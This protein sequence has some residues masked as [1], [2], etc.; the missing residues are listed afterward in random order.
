MAIKQRTGLSSLSS[1][2]QNPNVKSGVF[3]ARVIY[4]MLDDQTQVKAFKEFG[5]WSSIGCIFFDQ[6][7]Q[8]NPNPEF[9][10]DNFAK[11]LFPN[12]SIVPLENEIVYIIAL[13][14]S[15]IQSDVNDISY[16]YFQPVNIWNSVHHNAIP[17]PITGESVPESQQQDIC[18]APA[19]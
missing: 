12:Q 13:P 11:P 9:T 16:Y 15:D 5:E 17:D 2:P 1:V 4:A 18:R 3:S 19:Q 7:N 6:I 8:P 14:S 10:S